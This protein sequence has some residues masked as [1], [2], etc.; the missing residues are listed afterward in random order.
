MLIHFARNNCNHA[1]QSYHSHSVIAPEIIYYNVW[2]FKWALSL[3]HNMTQAFAFAF[4]LD[5][6]RR[7]HFGYSNEERFQSRLFDQIAHFSRV[8]F[9]LQKFSNKWKRTLSSLTFQHIEIWK[10][11]FFKDN[12]RKLDLFIV[13][14]SLEKCWKLR[15]LAWKEKK[16]ISNFEKAIRY[17]EHR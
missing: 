11:I 13:K 2:H 4:E 12:R 15:F 14:I 1:K 7:C 16:N 17:A 10:C 6:F 5:E 9:S 8:P 3:F